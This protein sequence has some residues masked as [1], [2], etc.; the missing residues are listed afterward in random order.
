M[1]RQR[2]SSSNLLS[3]GYDETTAILEIE[4]F[5]GPIY[6]FYNIPYN[7]YTGLMLAPSKG[8]YFDS[9]IRKGR[10]LYH[11]GSSD[12]SITSLKRNNNLSLPATHPANQKTTI[13]LTFPNRTGAGFTRNPFQQGSK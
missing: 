1:E 11:L 3:I 4:F 9:R 13:G 6:T 8:C 7:L 12:E 10:F 5:A 2:V